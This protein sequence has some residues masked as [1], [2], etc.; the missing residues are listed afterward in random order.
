MR[1]TLSPEYDAPSPVASSV[2]PDSA[3]PTP[4]ASDPAQAARPR[5]RLVEPWLAAALVVA[6]AL[7]T[8]AGERGDVSRWAPGS[9]VVLGIAVILAM[10]SL[11]ISTL[12]PAESF[13]RLCRWGLAHPA[14]S[15]LL[16]GLASF[17][18]YASISY[19]VF[20]ASPLNLDEV[21]QLFQARIFADGALWRTAP[22]H[23][24]FFSIY[25]IV[26]VGGRV[27][28]QFPPGG[29]AMLALGELLGAAWLVVPLSGAIAVMAWMSAL[30]AAEPRPGVRLG[31]SL[32]FAL[33]PFF[34]FLAGTSMN[35]VPALMWMLIGVAALVRVTH[36]ERSRAWWALG[37]GLAFGIAGTIR[38]SDALAFALP[39]AAWLVARASRDRARWR[40][41]AAA[42]AGVAIPLL[43]MAIVN[44]LTTGAPLRFGYEV[45]WGKAHGIGFHADPS[46]AMHTPARG[47]SQMS[48]YLRSLQEHLFELPLPSLLPVLL[49]FALGRRTSAL[50][51]YLLASAA[52]LLS[53]YTAYWFDGQYL[54][55]RF[56]IPMVPLL[57]LW[58]ARLPTLV[59]ERA[60]DG[61]AIR[62]TAYAYAVAIGMAA[63]LLVPARARLYAAASPE[64]RWDADSAA[65]AAGVRG[66]VVLVR[67][68][69]GSQLLAR[70]HSSGI[71]RVDASR[72]YRRTD[73]CLLEER[74]ASVERSE[75]RGTR[76]LAAL[77]PLVADSARVVPS[78]FS[79]RTAE[80]V[81][82]GATY[83][84]RCLTRIQQ[85]RAGFT[86]LVPLVL[87]RDNV[88]ARDLHERN[89][90]L[91]TLWPGR[92]V[93]LLK[94]ESEAPGAP[95]RFIPVSSDSLRALS[96][97]LGMGH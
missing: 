24:E 27:Y 7:L 26:D 39:A 29:P 38:P 49:A 83:G 1:H 80:R 85:D 69:W 54:G 79:P 48:G 56:L 88:Y 36:Q 81:L 37:C 16:L 4:P 43:A 9:A 17:A 87:A 95:M 25:H 42:G 46:G 45:L 84:P 82:P 19:A 18:L 34:A 31:A 3:P 93:Y 41:L 64:M 65:A 20:D 77:A 78:P 14:R 86:S 61:L 57:A 97:A 40:E 22:P 58:T 32:L 91:L 5:D 67:E 28:G 30:G 51:R 6:L 35:H 70:L 89:A 71:S 59:R 2:S 53:L 60:G 10:L 76:A 13:A 47:L 15:M 11:S 50:D 8:L 55:P 21:A 66:A 96:E 62:T 23:P 73:S 33:S 75:L 74:L 90:L 92:P 44:A 68:S 12:W 72:L 63:V 52:L 94:P